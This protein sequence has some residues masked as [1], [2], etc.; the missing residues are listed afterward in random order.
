MKFLTQFKLLL[1]FLTNPIQLIIS[2]LDS[3]IKQQVTSADIQKGEQWLDIGCG[4]RPYEDLFP[5][6]SYV[7]ID[8]EE[9]GRAASLKSADLYYD[10]YNFPFLAETFDGVLCTEVLEHVEDTDK[11]LSNMA[12]IVKPGGTLVLTVPFIWQQ[13]ETPYDFYRFTEFGLRSVLEK[14]GFLYRRVKLRLVVRLKVYLFYLFAG[15]RIR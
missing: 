1:A 11:F 10:G 15:F 3:A 5:D 2:S 12:D 7:G 9:S 14:N 13:H 8:V 4:Q 6:K